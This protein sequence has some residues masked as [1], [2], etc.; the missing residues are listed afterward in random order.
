VDIDDGW[1]TDR[2]LS[3][4]VGRWGWLHVRALVEE[5]A[6]GRCLCRVAA[7]LQPSVRGILRAVLLSAALVGASSAAIALRWPWVTGAAVAAAVVLFVSAAWQT[8]R[9]VA[10]LDRALAR[11]TT[12]AG[13]ITLPGRAAGPRLTWR[14]STVLHK[15]QAALVLGVVAA[16]LIVSG[17]FLSR[18][19][20][21][22]TA[23]AP[24]VRPRVIAPMGP[25]PQRAAPRPADAGDDLRRATGRRPDPAPSLG[26]AR[27]RRDDPRSGI[28]G[29]RAAQPQAAPRRVPRRTA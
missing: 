27:Q 21:Q 29:G 10:V 2:D 6:E 13:M 14:P 22:R 9:S 18:D 20:A 19:L 23:D 15:G 28:G 26:T 25:V 16:S 17:L 4:A 5:H 8:T 3:M 12:Q 11:V 24:A 1:H 7:R